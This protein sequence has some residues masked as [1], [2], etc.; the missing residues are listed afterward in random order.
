MAIAMGILTAIIILETASTS[1]TEAADTVEM[2]AT[3]LAQIPFN[4]NAEDLELRKTSIQLDSHIEGPAADLSASLNERRLICLLL[5]FLTS[6][7]CGEPRLPTASALSEHLQ[8]L[9][10]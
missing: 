4:W 8:R 5:Q 9:G 2:E 6:L 7:S 1:R 3:L 10:G